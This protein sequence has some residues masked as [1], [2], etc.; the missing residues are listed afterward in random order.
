[1][2]G[3]EDTED[4]ASAAQDVLE[5]QRAVTAQMVKTDNPCRGWGLLGGSC[6]MAHGLQ[7]LASEGC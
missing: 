2:A 3:S 4:L 7:V 6:L 1:M 5:E